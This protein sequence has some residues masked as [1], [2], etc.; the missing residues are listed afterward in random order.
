MR[1]Y[2]AWYYNHCSFV[3]APYNGLIARMREKGFTKPGRAVANP[4]DLS[5]FSPATPLER[6]EHRRSFGVTGP[7]VLYV[8]RLGVE[9]RLDVILRGIALLKEELP[10]LTFVMTGHGAAEERLRALAR[11]LHIEKNVRFTGF[12]SRAT[13]PH[14][15]KAA[16]VFAMMSTSDSQSLALMQAY[17]SG[18]P[19]VCARAR[20]LPDYTPSSCGYLVAPGDYRALAEKL[21][22]LLRNDSMRARM[23]EAGRTFS[24]QFSP[25]TIAR[26][27]EDRYRGVLGA[28]Y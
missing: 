21:S 10:A 25:D 24:K 12:L 8:G 15:Y 27:W 2:D 13:L 28:K 3:S 18:M 1:A 22:L 6:E 5:A 23:G 11:E 16:D 19:A 26:E 7:V 17:A 4:V 20:G 9:K 14:V